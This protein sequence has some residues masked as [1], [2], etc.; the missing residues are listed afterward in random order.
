MAYAVLYGY[1][2]MLMGASLEQSLAAKVFSM[3][4]HR[5]RLIHCV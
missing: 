4:S 5:T 1:L 3:A 2:Q